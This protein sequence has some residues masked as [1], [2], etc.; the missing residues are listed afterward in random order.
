V[1]VRALAAG[2]R[3]LAPSLQQPLEPRAAPHPAIDPFHLV[4]TELD[5]LVGEIHRELEAELKVDSELGEMAKYYFDGGGKGLRP[6]IAMCLG[7]AFNAHT[8][9]VGIAE[10]DQRKV[11]GGTA[12]RL[13][14][15]AIPPGGRH[16]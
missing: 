14:L 12:R 8:G 2:P 15:T 5:S 7:H 9:R 4:H 6:V 10:A 13:D 1:A 3:L 16:I 11:R